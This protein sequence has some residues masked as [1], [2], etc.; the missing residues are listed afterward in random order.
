[1]PSNISKSLWNPHPT[2][3]IAASLSR[4][5]WKITTTMPSTSRPVNC[6]GFFEADNI[7][8]N[9]Q[10]CWWLKS[11]DHHLRLVVYPIIL[12]VVLHPNGVCIH[13]GGCKALLQA[14]GQPFYCW[15]FRNPANQLSLVVYSV[16]HRV[17]YIPGGAGFHPST[18]WLPAYK[19]RLSGVHVVLDE[20]IE[21][22][23][24]K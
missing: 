24:G 20:A 11:G 16:I 9:T 12:N 7:K 23:W 13:D 21:R 3:P 14:T 18:V 2:R 4:A 17:S 8:E 6:H 22:A 10:C 15:W 19:K 5:R 1:M